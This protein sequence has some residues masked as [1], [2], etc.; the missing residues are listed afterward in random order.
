M[1]IL[2][3]TPYYAP[4]YAFGGVPRVVEGM[5]RALVQSG[6]TL[7]ILTTDALSPSKRYNLL[8]EMQ[9]EIRVIR[10]PNLSMWLRG[11]VNLSTPLTIH[12]Q[13][14]RLLADIDLIHVHEFRTVEN[15]LTIPLAAQ[16][17]IPVV[18]SPHGTLPHGTGRS[19]LKMGWDRIISPGM[20]RK[21]KGVIGLTAH[22]VDDAQ[23]LWQTFTAK[24]RFT[25]IPNGIDMNEFMNLPD[26]TNFRE[27]YQL[28]N[29]N[30]VLFMGRLHP[31]KGVDVLAKAFLQADIPN[32]RLLIVGPDEGLQPML[33]NLAA[34]DKRIVL[35]GYLA[36]EDRLAALACA[37]WFALPAIGEGL[38]MS[39]LEA[40]AVGVPV[41]L[42]PECYLP[43]V[44]AVGAGK[45]V[46]VNID[47]LAQTLK[48]VLTEP[49]MQAQM[50]THAKKLIR[51]R[52][53]WD[54]VAG[55]L[56]GFY[57]DILAD[58]AG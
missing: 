14:Q 41:I 26:P 57:R 58:S 48:T 5:A 7:T 40:M 32:S 8:E 21:I 49:A 20:A 27:R 43:E 1:H 46:P 25:A 38:P 52:F 35:T 2:H 47:A 4:A 17:D 42:S 37:D 9:N 19:I 44:E 16:N 31:R 56:D 23:R 34:Q 22:E 18:L 39:A 13:L 36:G 15:L 30:V 55:Q 50:R 45:I 11:R 24:S 28:N 53:T 54:I 3:I 51:D 33:R 29:A 10:V 12:N 6:H